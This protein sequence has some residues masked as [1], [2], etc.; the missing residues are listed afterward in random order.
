MKELQE[1]IKKREE[2]ENEIGVS[3]L[4]VGKGNNGDVLWAE[5]GRNGMLLGVG[6]G[7]NGMY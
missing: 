5:R 2:N 3:E 7:R 1:I 4:G 6:R